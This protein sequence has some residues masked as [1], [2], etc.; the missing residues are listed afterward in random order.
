MISFAVNIRHD[1]VAFAPQIFIFNS[2][3]MNIIQITFVKSFDHF[4]GNA[5][6]Q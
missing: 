5:G 6:N 1:I 3:C 2:L 4:G